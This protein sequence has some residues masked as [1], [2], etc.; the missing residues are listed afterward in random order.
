[1][2]TDKRTD[3]KIWMQLGVGNNV[4]NLDICA[5]FNTLGEDLSSSLAAFH[6][7]TRCN[8]NPAFCRK[9]KARPFKMLEK[10]PQYQEAFAKMGDPRIIANEDVMKETYDVIQDFVC[11]LYNVRAVSYAHLDV[12]KR[13]IL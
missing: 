11:L 10:S 8:F 6:A 3:R 7:F 2:Q 1:M 5:I 12:Y 9:A 4:R 13:Q